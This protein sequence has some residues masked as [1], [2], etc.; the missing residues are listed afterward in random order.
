MSST[1]LIN[2]PINV[3]R[4]EGKV[5]DIKKVIY[6]IM[7]IHQ[8]LYHQTKCPSFSS[9]DLY[10]YLAI[11]LKNT[12]FPID[13]MFEIT[14]TYLNQPSE[15]FKNI[16]IKEVVEF[17]KSEYFNKNNNSTVR[18]HFIDVRDYIYNTL[19]NY[20]NVLRDI[21]NHINCNNVI[22]LD[23]MEDIKH[24][25][26]LLMQEL[27]YWESLLFGD[28]KNVKNITNQNLKRLNTDKQLNMHEIQKNIK[29]VPKFIYKI[30]E[31]YNNP[32]IREKINV[33]FKHI[34]YQFK[35]ARDLSTYIITELE[36]NKN[37]FV[38]SFVL[39]Y[40]KCLQ[41][42]F[43]GQSSCSN[44]EL[45]KN[46]VKSHEM[47][48]YNILKLFSNIMDIYFLRRFLDKNYIKH[49]L[50]Y[51]GAAHSLNYLQHLITQYDF[52]ITHVSYSFEKDL[53]KLNVRLKQFDDTS[54]RRE[55]EKNFY[56]PQLIQCSDL[57]H[58]PKNF[59]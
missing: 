49:A 38:D 43:Y 22:S 16:Y 55:F 31:R 20:E 37:S 47:L 29:N 4:L 11:N 32:E 25:M 54:D 58:F 27:N 44:L 39:K 42:F 14:Q 51:T 50:V 13:F 19:N 36:N 8:R 2:G 57:S 9:L 24:Y 10:Q 35:Y 23:T 3:I 46:I 56:P 5:G 18:Y 59:E 7:D 21:F 1:L 17:F 12:N 34:S 26:N 33:I 28:L 6:L 48:S 52:K 41:T 30:R 15:Y 45:I 40:D 53:N